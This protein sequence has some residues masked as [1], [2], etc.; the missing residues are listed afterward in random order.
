MFQGPFLCKQS[1]PNFVRNG[2]QCIMLVELWARGPGRGGL[3][4]LAPGSQLGRPEGSGD[5][6][7]GGVFAHTSGGC[8]C[9]QELLPWC[10]GFLPAQQQG[11]KDKVSQGSQ[12]EA[13]SC[14]LASSRST[15]AA[16]VTTPHPG[17]QTQG[18]GGQTS[19]LDGEAQSSREKST[20]DEGCCCDHGGK[21]NG[22]RGSHRRWPG[23][24]VTPCGRHPAPSVR[25]TVSPILQVGQLRLV[26]LL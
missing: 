25:G 26:S 6:S 20:R 24:G 14:P 1:P 15:L 17:P 22:P 19:P 9:R 2:N 7:T 8:R 11:S 18:D 10:L 4:L 13:A 21:C 5:S 16:A 23:A 12:G 3:A